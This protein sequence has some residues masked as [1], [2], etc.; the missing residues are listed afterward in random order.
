MCDLREMGRRGPP[1]SAR[2][3]QFL[4]GY[5]KREG[6]INYWKNPVVWREIK[7]T[8]DRFLERHPNEHGW[9]RNYAWYAY[10]GERRD[11]FNRQ[12]PLFVTGTDYTYFGGKETFDRM[13]ENARERSAPAPR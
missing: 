8:L 4:A 9:S 12:L 13:V 2:C 7:S 3:P 6:D 1:A 11:D 5:A 10:H